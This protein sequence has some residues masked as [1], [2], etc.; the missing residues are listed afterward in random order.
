MVYKKH[1]CYGTCKSDSRYSD[2]KLWTF[3]THKLSWNDKNSAQR[4]IM[5]KSSAV[6][7]L[8]ALYTFCTPWQTCSFRQKCPIFETVA[9]GGFE[10]GL[11][12]LR[13]RHFT[14]EL[15]LPKLGQLTVFS[16]CDPRHSQRDM[17]TNEA[18][19]WKRTVDYTCS[20]TPWLSYY[21]H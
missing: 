12:W 5:R 16:T 2:S 15:P 18:T 17:L 19:R 13:V 6:G 14:A 11:T 3:F 9:K 8:K 10:P 7:P 1:C 21:W 4:K 20:F